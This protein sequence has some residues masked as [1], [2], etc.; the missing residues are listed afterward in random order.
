MWWWNTGH[1]YRAGYNLR[2]HLIAAEAVLR[3]R[4]PEDEMSS[5]RNCECGFSIKDSDLDAIGRILG[6]ELVLYAHTWANEIFTLTVRMRYQPVSVVNL[7][8]TTLGGGHYDVLFKREPSEPLTSVID[9]DAEDAGIAIEGVGVGVRDVPVATTNT[10]APECR[11]TEDVAPSG[12]AHEEDPLVAGLASYGRSSMSAA[13]LNINVE[14]PKHHLASLFGHTQ[15][16]RRYGAYHPDPY[17]Q[18]EKSYGISVDVCTLI[19]S[20]LTSMAT[21]LVNATE[22]PSSCNAFGELTE[23]LPTSRKSR[24]VP[25]REIKRR[26][27]NMEATCG[28]IQVAFCLRVR[29]CFATSQQSIY[30]LCVNWFQVPRTEDCSAKAFNDGIGRFGFRMPTQ[31]LLASLAG[32]S[33]IR[34]RIHLASLLTL[35]WNE[36]SGNTSSHIMRGTQRLRC[37]SVPWRRWPCGENFRGSTRFWSSK[38]PGERGRQ[39][40]LS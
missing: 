18:W 27:R 13:C 1:E 28:E 17:Y 9:V 36:L 26:C 21:F 14:C 38:I 24:I 34:S 35:L 7:L 19:C 33:T 4:I 39:L 37:W 40:G 25:D 15:K 29:H 31:P 10:V 12:R 5:T 16:S 22:L 32:T 8:F 20:I 30:T 2:S 11:P 23:A 3:S 6:M